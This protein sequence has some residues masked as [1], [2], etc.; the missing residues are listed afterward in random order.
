MTQKRVSNNQTKNLVIMLILV[1]T[2]IISGL[3][4]G[5][6]QAEKSPLQGLVELLTII[7]AITGVSY[8]GL[9]AWKASRLLKK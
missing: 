9:E 2:L 1:T 3:L 4:A 5:K 6:L 8:L 7:V